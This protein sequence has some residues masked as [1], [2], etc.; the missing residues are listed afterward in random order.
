M[1]ESGE[2]LML[3]FA[4]VKDYA[5]RCA[6]EGG[7][8]SSESGARL[9]VVTTLVWR[10]LGP[11]CALFDTLSIVLTKCRKNAT[12]ATRWKDERACRMCLRIA[13]RRR[14][15]GAGRRWAAGRMPAA[16]GRSRSLSIGTSSTC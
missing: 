7:R 15:C 8:G 3:F 13:A 4:F 1:G 6:D 9:L 2:V 11:T 5:S 16:R 12:R 10:A 14:L